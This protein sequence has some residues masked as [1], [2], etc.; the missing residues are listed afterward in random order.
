MCRVCRLR[1]EPRRSGPSGWTRTTTS[2][3][4]SP[5]C[6]VDTTEGSGADPGELSERRS[7]FGRSSSIAIAP[8]SRG[9]DDGHTRTAGFR[10]I[11]SA[12]ERMTGFEP[13]PQGL[14]GPRATVTPHSLW[15]GLRVSNPSRHAGNVECILHTQAEHG[16]VLLTGPSTSFQFSKTPLMTS[17][18][19]ARDSNPSAPLGENG[20]T[21]RQRTIR[22]YRPYGD[23][24]R[25]RTRTH[26]LWRLGCFCYTTLPMSPHVSTDS[27]TQPP[28]DLAHTS[29]GLEAKTK[30]AF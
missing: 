14:E 13:V 5:A 3:V 25:T 4:K 12:L 17:W 16:P 18:W 8:R 24:A 23:S 11:R 6:C 10:Y 27:K 1:H 26:E 19:A 30:K 15:F 28:S 7:E 9:Q 22:S 29:S 2:R 21:A 20:V